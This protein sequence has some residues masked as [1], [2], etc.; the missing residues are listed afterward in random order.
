[1]DVCTFLEKSRLLGG[2]LSWSWLCC[3]LVA[4]IIHAIGRPPQ[5]T[6]CVPELRSQTTGIQ[7]AQRV[8]GQQAVCAATAQACDLGPAYYKQSGLVCGFGCGGQIRKERL[9]ARG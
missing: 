1:M 5:E 9:G 6:V 3:G 7:T 4:R 2:V 8:F